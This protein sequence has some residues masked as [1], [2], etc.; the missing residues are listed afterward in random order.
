MLK[1]LCASLWELATLFE[2]R[3]KT[4]KIHGALEFNQ[5][6]W[7]KLYMAHKK[8]YNKNGENYGKV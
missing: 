3:T 5:R 4:K 6:Q 8:E 2:T 1:N 7:L